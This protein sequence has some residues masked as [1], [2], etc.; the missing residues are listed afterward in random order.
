MSFVI[1]STDRHPAKPLSCPR[2]YYGALGGLCV[3]KGSIDKIEVGG[4]GGGGAGDTTNS[5]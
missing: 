4:G 3:K 5:E 2:N 1:F